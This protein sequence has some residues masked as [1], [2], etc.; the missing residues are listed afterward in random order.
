MGELTEQG[1]DVRLVL[2]PIFTVERDHTGALIGFRGDGPAVGAARRESFIHIHVERIED[3]A[4]QERD[5]QGDRRGARRRAAVRRRLA[6]DAGARR[7]A[8]RRD[9]EQSAAAAGGRDRRGDPVPRMAG[10][11]QLHVPRRA[12]IRHD[13]RR[14]RLHGGAGQRARH[15]ALARR[16]RA[17]PRQRAG[18]DHAGDHGV[19][20][21]AAAAHHHQGERA[22]ARA[23]ARAHGLHRGEALRRRR[24]ADRRIP[25][26][27]PVHLHGLYALDALD[28][29]S[30]AQGRQPDAP[31]RLRSGQPFRQ[32][33]RGGAGEL[34]RATSCS[35]STRTRSTASCS[36]SCIST[37]ARACACCR[38]AIA[39]TASSRS[40][41][42]CRATATTPAIAHRD[43]ALSGERLQ[44]ARLG[45]LSVL[46]RRAAGARALH[47]RAPSG[48]TPN[49]D[50]ATLEQRGRADRAHLD[51]R[52]RRG[53]H[54]GA[55]AG[56]G[57]AAH[58]PLPRGVPGRL[59]RGLCAAGRGRRHPPDRKPL[60]DPPARRR[61][62]H[63]GAR[64]MP[65]APA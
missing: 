63:A 10:R 58:A 46:P 51:R 16:A 1:L 43:R 39:S 11:Q 5:R 52:A 4:R 23:P 54:A 17:A 21:R 30:P 20:A 37:S 25:H 15:P 44:R 29:V 61:L 64:A 13:R 36:P 6:A 34:L 48:E 24:A 31:L 45:V 40:W 8:D 22:L 50:R 38:G 35:R 42:T 56:Q 7:R 47:H 12:R 57:A 49:P 19:P 65:P 32:G 28:P 3:E 2:H 41:C 60:A 33:I 14:A 55:R 62:L 9:Q 53:A 26:R 18:V 27:R 59:S